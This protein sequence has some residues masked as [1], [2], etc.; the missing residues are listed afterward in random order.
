MVAVVVVILFRDEIERRMP[1]G[2]VDL[3][4]PPPQRIVAIAGHRVSAR[5][6]VRDPLAHPHLPV[7]RV[8]DVA[9]DAVSGQVPRGVVD[10]VRL[11]RIA[12]SIFVD[13]SIVDAVAQ[14]GLWTVGCIGVKTRVN[15][16]HPSIDESNRREASAIDFQ[17]TEDVQHLGLHEY[18]GLPIDVA[19]GMFRIHKR[20]TLHDSPT[21]DFPRAHNVG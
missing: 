21:E 13:V 20:D 14:I 10:E 18:P 2:E 1:V 15:R 19:L 6:R 11:L 9:E 17:R 5:G 7:E 12:G 16:D 3:L 4:D 8:V